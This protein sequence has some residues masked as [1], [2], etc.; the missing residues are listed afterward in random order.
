M[1]RTP[2]GPPTHVVP[3]CVVAASVATITTILPWGGSGERRRSSY[4]IVDIAARAGVVPDAFDDLTW[5]WHLAP[6][7]CGVVLI[8]ASL[9]RP[10]AVGVASTTLGGLIVAGAVLVS[11][12]PLAAE[13]GALAGGLAGVVTMMSGAAAFAVPWRTTGGKR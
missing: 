7:L 9:H 3:V 2:T 10:R 12:S 1:P 13:P 11:T 6:A 4:E 5:I 8:A